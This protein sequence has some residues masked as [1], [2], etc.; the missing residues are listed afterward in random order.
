MNRRNQAELSAAL[1]DRDVHGENP[2]DQLGSGIAL[3][4]SL[5][6]FIPPFTPPFIPFRSF[7]SW[8]GAAVSTILARRRK[9][10]AVDRGARRTAPGGVRI[11]VDA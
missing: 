7:R 11:H 4:T 10:A 5:L 2:L 3:S 8:H 1:A 6:S 9:H